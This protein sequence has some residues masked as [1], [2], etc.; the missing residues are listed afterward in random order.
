MSHYSVAVFHREDQN[1]EDLLAP[2]NENIEVAPYIQFTKQQA[3][4]YARKHFPAYCDGKTDDEC[5]KYMAED[6]SDDM[7]DKDGNLYTTYNPKSKWDW[8]EIGGRYSGMLL[9]KIDG[10]STDFGRIREID[11]PFDQDEYN[12]ALRFW[13]VWIA[14]TKMPNNEESQY[15]SRYNEDYHIKW[16]GN[17]QEY[18][19]ECGN[20]STYA[21]ITLDG[22]WH[23]PG[24][25]GWWGTST[26]SIEEVND[27]Y[28][29]YKKNWIDTADP[30][31]YVTIVDC[32]I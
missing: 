31:W 21:V 10:Y 5:Y 9:D 2:Y 13:D 20:F 29:N 28:K 14:K 26:E 23:S 19:E 12:A 3:V 30:E 1:I 8:Y 24:N 17:R 15:P 22:E 16:Y 18:A 6:Y 25:V 27:W 32:H 11:F 4:D 7:I